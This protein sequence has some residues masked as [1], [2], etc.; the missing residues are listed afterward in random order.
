MKEGKRG[1]RR[2]GK[3]KRKRERPCFSIKVVN[4]VIL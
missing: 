4:P 1:K 2:T 3:G